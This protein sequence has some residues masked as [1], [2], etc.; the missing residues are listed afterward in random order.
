[1][2]RKRLFQ[3]FVVLLCV[4]SFSSCEEDSIELFEYVTAYHQNNSYGD[5]RIEVNGELVGYITEPFFG[6]E[7]ECGSLGADRVSFSIEKGEVYL[8]EVFFG[9]ASTPFISGFYQ[10]LDEFNECAII[11]L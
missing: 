11:E 3:G 2:I 5:L 1:M 8:L 7:L 6:S 9:E 10:L 4:L